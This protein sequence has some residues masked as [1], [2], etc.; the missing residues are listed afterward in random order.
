MPIVR[1]VG[2]IIKVDHRQKPN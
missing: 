1:S 2:S